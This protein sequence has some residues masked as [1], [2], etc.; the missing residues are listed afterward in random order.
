[1]F[2][3]RSN[4]ITQA[5]ATSIGTETMHGQHRKSIY[6]LYTGEAATGLYEL[7]TDTRGSYLGKN[8]LG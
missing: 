8:L 7:S 2:V 3:Q 1:M 4:Q 5:A 6:N